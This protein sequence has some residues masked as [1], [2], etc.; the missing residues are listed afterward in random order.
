MPKSESIPAN[1]KAFISRTIDSVGCLEVLLLLRG[2]PQT[3][4]TD[5]MV[6]RELRSNPNFARMQLHKLHG[7][8]LVSVRLENQ[9]E[10]YIYAPSSPEVAATV[11]ELAAQYHS[12]RVTLIG[13]I[14]ERNDSIQLFSDAFKLRKD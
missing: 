9:N 2:S 8:G 4:W 3:E 1:L 7:H 11:D 12:H 6:S 10:T 13:L 14:Y 5:E